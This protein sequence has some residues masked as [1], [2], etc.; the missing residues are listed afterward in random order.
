MHSVAAD[1]SAEPTALLTGMDR[2]LSGGR[3][4]VAAAIRLD[5]GK[6]AFRGVGNVAARLGGGGRPHGLVSSM[7]TLGLAQRL[8]PIAAL[9]PW[10]AGSVFI[11]HTDGLRPGWDLSRY[12]GAAARDPAIMAALIWRDAVTRADD[13]A[14]IVVVP[15]AMEAAHER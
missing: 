2:R 8:R 15:P 3:G 6:L 1:V 11:A 14:V 9:L 13:A 7:G 4:A 12:P 5:R 10:G